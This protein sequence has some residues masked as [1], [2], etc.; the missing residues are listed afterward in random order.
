M[1]VIGLSRIGL[2]IGVA[3]CGT[4]LTANHIKLIKRYTN[5]VY[6]LFDSDPA[7]FDATIRALK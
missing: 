2:E 6:F 4:S 5:N 3:T 1:D 7:G